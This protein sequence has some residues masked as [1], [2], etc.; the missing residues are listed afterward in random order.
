MQSPFLRPWCVDLKET[1]T[2]PQGTIGR[3]GVLK[4][5]LQPQVTAQLTKYG[6]SHELKYCDPNY[7]LVLEF[8]CN[9]SY[10]KFYNA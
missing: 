5:Q 3:T 1:A 7:T 4:F 10:D 6:R 2:L 9:I 8:M